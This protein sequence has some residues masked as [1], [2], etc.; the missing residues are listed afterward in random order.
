MKCVGMMVCV[1]CRYFDSCATPAAVDSCAESPDDEQF[2]DFE[3]SFRGV[4][5]FD[6]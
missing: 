1:C 4:F 6:E 3:F 2:S 5:S